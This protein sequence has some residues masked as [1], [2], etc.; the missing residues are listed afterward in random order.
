MSGSTS[1]GFASPKTVTWD[2]T[3]HVDPLLEMLYGFCLKVQAT[4][5]S[6]S[7]AP[8]AKAPVAKRIDSSLLQQNQ[9]PQDS[10]KTLIPATQTM[11]QNPL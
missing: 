11:S 8:V 1:S 2:S 6:L 10:K 3:E 5:P 9:D 4:M 7:Q